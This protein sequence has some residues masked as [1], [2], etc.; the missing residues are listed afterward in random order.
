[1]KRKREPLKN[2]SKRCTNTTE[3]KKIKVVKMTIREKLN[4]NDS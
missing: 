1:M 4:F 2:I 3:Y